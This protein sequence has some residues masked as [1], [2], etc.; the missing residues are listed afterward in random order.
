MTLNR[1]IKKR[2]LKCR[3]H[4]EAQT[5]AHT[6]THGHSLTAALSECRGDGLAILGSLE[7][8]PGAV[9]G[10]GG[11]GEAGRG[12]AADGGVVAHGVEALRLAALL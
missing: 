7:V 10:A 8:R 9:S 1:K 4:T 3:E 11:F 12:G 5:H 6:H 2:T